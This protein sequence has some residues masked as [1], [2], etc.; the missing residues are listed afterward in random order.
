MEE[1]KQTL[2]LTRFNRKERR[3]IRKQTHLTIP[4]R[5]LPFVK[6]LHGTLEDYYAK[7]ELEISKEHEDN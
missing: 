1:T 3:N 6:K 4:G 7:R 2:D 5:N